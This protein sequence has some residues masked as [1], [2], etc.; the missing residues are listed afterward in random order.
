[1]SYGMQYAGSPSKGVAGIRADAAALERA[2]RPFTSERILALRARRLAREEDQT[3]DSIFRWGR[4]FSPGSAAQTPEEDKRGFQI[5]NPKPNKDP[6][7]E[8]PVLVY[9]EVVRVT[10][11]VRVK[12]PQDAQ[13]YVDVER[14]KSITFRGPDGVDRRFDLN[15]PPGTPVP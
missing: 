6:N 5:V 3:D 7:E 11:T 12:N 4:P 8:K 13:Q 1:M 10:D 2:V 14:I 9:T 15:P